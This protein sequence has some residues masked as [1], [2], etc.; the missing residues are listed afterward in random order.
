[1]K[2]PRRRQKSRWPSPPPL[3]GWIWPFA[4]SALTHLHR[5]SFLLVL[6]LKFKYLGISFQMLQLQKINKEFCMGKKKRG[7]MGSP[8]FSAKL[9]WINPK[10]SIFSE[11]VTVTRALC[12]L[13]QKLNVLN[14]AVLM[15]NW[16]VLLLP[17]ILNMFD[18]MPQRTRPSN[19]QLSLSS[20]HQGGS[21]RAKNGFWQVNLIHFQN[22]YSH[23]KMWFTLPWLSFL[24]WPFH[25]YAN[26][27]LNTAQRVIIISSFVVSFS[28]LF[29]WIMIYFIGN[30][31]ITL[32]FLSYDHFETQKM[33]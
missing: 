5:S 29:D 30:T 19:Y 10:I 16:S 1:M 24:V 21:S 13:R 17:C 23:V 20:D 3:D 11:S 14:V 18:E 8:V 7:K 15:L 26:A 9:R 31:I 25:G 33:K 12:T 32:Q 22:Q 2:P 6:V 4:V 27:C 28:H